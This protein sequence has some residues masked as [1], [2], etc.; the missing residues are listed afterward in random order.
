[1]E[2]YE[3]AY[4]FYQLVGTANTL[5][6]LTTTDLKRMESNLIKYTIK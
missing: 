5:N 2:G 3:Q 1:M 4:D 6:R